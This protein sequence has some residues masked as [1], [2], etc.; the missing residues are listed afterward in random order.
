[1]V[2]KYILWDF[3]GTLA[4][5]EGK[6]SGALA[7]LANRFDPVNI[8]TID[9]FKP[10]LQS[11]FPWHSPEIK[12]G[13]RT[14]DQWW[15]DIQPVFYD[16]FVQ[17]G[18]PSK[19]AMQLARSVRFEY[20]NKDHWI[21]Y[22][23]V[24]ESLSYFADRG[25]QQCIL[26][27]HIPELAILVEDLGLDVY[28]EHVFSSANIGYEKPHLGFFEYAISRLP[29]CEKFWM[30]GDNYTA[31]ILGAEAANLP[32]VLVR[33]PHQSARLQCTSLS[34]LPAIIN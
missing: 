29:K 14:A 27:N 5:R 30:V 6:W 8:Y 7:S 13:E 11:G 10:A 23:D 26:S 3:D 9:A 17:A 31:D 32:A 15:E 34:G 33:K 12:Y 22:D 24:Q 19:P 2:T 18:V 25:W 1:L 21:V 4:H 20:T 28:F 16:A